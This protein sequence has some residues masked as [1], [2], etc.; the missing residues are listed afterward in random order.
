MVPAKD[1]QH[2]D[3]GSLLQ[4]GP[5][6]VFFTRPERRGNLHF[7][8]LPEQ[9]VR[10]APHADADEQSG[11]EAEGFESM[12]EKLRRLKPSLPN[13]DLRVL[14]VVPKNELPSQ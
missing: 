11:G 2:D 6:I 3:S 7:G 1:P 4:D 14:F 10:E 13:R 12:T 8:G 9:R 5:A